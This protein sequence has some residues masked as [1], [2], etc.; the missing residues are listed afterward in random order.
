[1]T[2]QIR[3][4]LLEDPIDARGVS[5]GADQHEQ[6]QLRMPAPELKLQRVGVVFV[7]V[8][9]DQLLRLLLRRLTAELAA[10]AA[11]AARDEHG[12][13]GDVAGDL[14]EIDLHDVAAEQI[15][16]VHL[17]QALDAH[18][19]IGDLIQAR[20]RAQT[21][22]RLLAQIHDLRALLA[23]GRGNREHDLLDAVFL[24]HLLELCRRAD[25][26]HAAQIAAGLGGI[27]VKNADN[28]VFRVLA[29]KKLP[30]D[31]R[32][33][34]AAADDHRAPPLGAVAAVAMEPRGAVAPA[35]CHAAHA[36][37]QHIHD[38]KAARH[39]QM[40]QVRPDPVGDARRATASRS[41]SAPWCWQTPTGWNTA[42]EDKRSAVSRR[43]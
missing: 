39:P 27:V 12:L 37:Q 4:I 28:L 25:D 13:A 26:A 3:M 5:H 41:G 20:K 30:N 17:A 8:E 31:H 33:G 34:S 7:N 16:D 29:V 36:E 43:C 35:H 40:Q 42:A 2:D 24:H 32:A 6:I 23:R 38:R 21:A 19:A 14:V 22:G 11:A 18:L 15:L 9:D 1:M 10:D